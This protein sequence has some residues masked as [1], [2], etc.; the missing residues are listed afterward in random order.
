MDKAKIRNNPSRFQSMKGARFISDRIEL[1][2]LSKSTKESVGKVSLH[3]VKF[4]EKRW[5]G[6]PVCHRTRFQD[7][8]DVHGK[9]LDQGFS[10]GTSENT[11]EQI[12]NSSSFESERIGVSSKVKCGGDE[13]SK[14][15][16]REASAKRKIDAHKG[17]RHSSSTLDQNETL[18]R[19]NTHLPS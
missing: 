8:P 6:R 3:F 10:R 17:E 15:S 9:G 18:C 2:G 13:K 14:V 4:A 16:F 12:H 19:L 11:K 1:M 5:T 7:T